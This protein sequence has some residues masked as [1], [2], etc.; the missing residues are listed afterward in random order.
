MEEFENVGF[1]FLGMRGGG[2][3][4]FSPMDTEK[5]VEPATIFANFGRIVVFVIAVC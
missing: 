5:K 3:M 2:T 4:F 1:V